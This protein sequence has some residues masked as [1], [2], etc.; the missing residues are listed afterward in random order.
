ML[1]RKTKDFIG[2]SAAA[3]EPF[4]AYVAPRAPH[5]SATPAPR[6]LHAYDGARAS[7]PPSFNEL[8]VSDKPPWIR[9][10][11]RLSDAEKRAIDDRHESRIESL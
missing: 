9:D 6:D 11:P 4:F 1:R 5:L 3:G 2:A 7:R 10:L 8:N